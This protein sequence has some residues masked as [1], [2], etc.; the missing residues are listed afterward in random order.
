M[1]GHRALQATA[2]AAALIAGCGQS[3]PA[4]GLNGGATAPQRLWPAPA[5]SQ[6]R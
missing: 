1:Q 3:A 2:A 6:W 5:L 4:P